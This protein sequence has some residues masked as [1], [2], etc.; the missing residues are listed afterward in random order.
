VAKPIVDG[1]EEELHGSVDFVRLDVATEVGRT[2]GQRWG[3]R[4]TPSFVL[5]DGA[6]I[7]AWRQV[8]VPDAGAVREVA[9]R[10]PPP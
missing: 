6:G 1:L 5:F 8:G 10:L 7:E 4:L 2:L 9:R 3:L